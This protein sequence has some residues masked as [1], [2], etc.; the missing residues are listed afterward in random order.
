MDIFRHVLSNVQIIK[1]EI[2][3]TLY[4]LYNIL[5]SFSIRDVRGRKLQ[6]I[7]ED[8]KF[9]RLAR[10]GE[11]K[12]GNCT[13]FAT[14]RVKID[15]LLFSSNRFPVWK[16]STSVRDSIPWRS[17]HRLGRIPFII[18]S[19]PRAKGVASIITS[20]IFVVFATCSPISPHSLAS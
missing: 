20:D 3:W 14:K 9:R 13:L 18:E 1:L 19:H 8:S 5:W 2:K 7:F 17:M 4:I 12:E 10:G 15:A 11:E 6:R 16:N